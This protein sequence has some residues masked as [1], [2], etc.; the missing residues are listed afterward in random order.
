MKEEVLSQDL[1]LN[2]LQSNTLP[3]VDA[4]KHLH[5]EAGANL[6]ALLDTQNYFYFIVE[7]K[8][9]LS[10]INFETS[11]EQTLYLLTRGDMFDVV[12]LLDGEHHDLLGEVLE[13]CDLIEV[14]M[15]NVR[16]LLDK[17]PAFKQLFFPYLAAQLRSMENLSIDLSLYDVYQRLIHL[18][19]R[20]VDNTKDKASL[21][22]IDNLSHEEIA[23]M[24]GSVRKVVNRNLQKL[25][26]EG[27]VNISRKHLSVENLK[28][29]R[30]KLKR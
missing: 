9:K 16:Y 28:K 6:S 8:V 30:D 18:L 10:Q 19:T 27:I 7:G 3:V 21:K 13:P 20:F 25:K 1:I 4:Q 12:T 23:S 24:I 11:K 29:L 14:P 2:E 26:D 15:D 22:M 5:L 17:D